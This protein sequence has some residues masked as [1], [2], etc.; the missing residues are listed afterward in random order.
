MNQTTSAPLVTP[1]IAAQHIGVKAGTMQM[2]RTTGRYAI[3]YIKVGKCVRYRLADLDAWLASRTQ[4][5]S[6]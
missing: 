1:E 4:N 6:V 2:W 5:A 3:P